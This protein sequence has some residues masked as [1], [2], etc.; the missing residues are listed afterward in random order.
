MTAAYFLQTRGPVWDRLAALLAK[1]RT[2]GARALSDEELHELTRLYPAVTVDVARARMYGIDPRTQQR[3]NGLAIAAHGVL[4]RRPDARP[5]KGIWRFFR[6]DYPRLFRRLWVYVALAGAIFAVGTVGAYVSVRLRPSMAYVFVPGGLDVDSAADVTAADVGERYRLMPKPSMATAITGNNISVA[7]Y[8]FALG[9]TAC[10][11]TCYVI[12]AN[13]M[14]LGAF[15]AHFANHGLSYVCY[16]FLVPHGALE[17]FAILVSAAAG[18]RLGISMWIPGA[19][20]RG[21]SLRKGAREAVLLVLGA[22]PMFVV[23]GIIESFITPSY[24]PGAAKIAIGVLVWATTMAYLLMGG[25]GGRAIARLRHN[26]RV[27]LISR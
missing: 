20:T 18:L 7:F 16:S 1:T 27:A 25:R 13:A 24:M 23:A 8:A 6:Q 26:R 10:V 19:L 5:M 15:F 21:A 9:I 22:I 4:Y 11:G 14:M 3:I 17:V 12:F 2:R